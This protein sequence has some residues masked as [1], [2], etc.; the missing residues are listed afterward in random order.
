MLL[1]AGIWLC[2]NT[3][4]FL[5]MLTYIK[6]NNAYYLIIA[7]LLFIL[8]H[9][10]KASR[11][12]LILLEAR[13]SSN[14][15]LKQY[16][17]TTL[18]TILIPFKLG[19]F[20]R[21]YCFSKEAKSYKVGLMG[22][23]IDRFFDTII[24]LLFILPY[25]LLDNNKSPYITM[26]IIGFLLMICMI[27][28]VIYITYPYLNHF[29]VL[30]HSDKKALIFLEYLE[31]MKNMQRDILKMIKGRSALI[32]FL[33]ALAWTIEFFA[34]KTIMLVLLKPFDLRVFG[35][36]LEYSFFGS[37]NELTIFYFCFSSI[38]IAFLSAYIY[39]KSFLKKGA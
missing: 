8:L 36:Y 30:H 19:E 1:L 10:I 31:Q 13:I 35:E 12:Y 34:L 22:V 24:L 27:N 7:V 25:Q 3:S 4:G 18:V 39:L 16:F 6:F 2:N 28:L 33:S 38:I 21:I 11:L 20:F 37:N 29:M 32:M 14:R 15:F 5:N 26:I 9:L 17:K 23:L